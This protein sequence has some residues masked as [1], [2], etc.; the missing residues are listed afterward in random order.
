MSNERKTNPELTHPYNPYYNLFD[1][2]VV[3][4][5]LAVGAV[6]LQNSRALY[7]SIHPFIHSFIPHSAEGKRRGDIIEFIELQSRSLYV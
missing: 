7:L 2:S 3:T 1:F 5:N 6:P 4:V